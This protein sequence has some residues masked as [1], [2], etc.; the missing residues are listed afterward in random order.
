M[1]QMINR[2]Y[3]QV[4]FVPNTTR[5]NLVFWH[6]LP[7][8]DLGQDGDVCID[9]CK[10]TGMWKQKGVWEKLAIGNPDFQY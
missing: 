5:S 10:R 2:P 6:G 8:D 4:V 3:L 9:P 1:A 7:P